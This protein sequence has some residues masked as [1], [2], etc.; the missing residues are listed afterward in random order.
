MRFF[1]TFCLLLGSFAGASAACPR[2]GAPPALPDG[3]HADEATMTAAHDLIQAHVNLLEAYQACLTKL[4]QNPPEDSPAELR[5]TWLAQGDAALDSAQI[6]ASNFSAE[7][8]IFKD[9][10]VK[11]APPK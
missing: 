4:A 3:A 1:L 6:L 9:S 11:A 2:P 10:H 7:L 5:L 8:K